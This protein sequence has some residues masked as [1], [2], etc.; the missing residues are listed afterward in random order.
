MLVLHD[1]LMQ[2]HD[3][4]RGHPEQPARLAAVKAALEDHPGLSWRVPQPGAREAIERVH[5][6]RYVEQIARL[7]GKSGALDGDTHLSTASVDAAFLAAGAAIDAVDAVMGGEHDR[8][9]A[10]V[11]PPGHH[12]ESSRAM[13]FCIFNNVAVA[14]AHAIAAHGLQ[15]VLV[16]DWDVH[17]GNGTQHSFS[18]RRDILFVSLHQFPFY[19]GTGAAEESGEGE[20]AGFTIN[21]PF[22]AGCDDQDYRAAFADLILPAADAFAP[23]LVLISAGFDAHRRDPLASMQVTEEGYAD[24]AAALKAVAD[25][26]AKGRMVLTLEGGYDLAALGQSAR[27]AVDVL[28]GATAAEG[29]ASPKRG[30]SAITQVRSHHK[31]LGGPLAGKSC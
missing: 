10:L 11:R 1:D 31:A 6:P 27:A 26:H 17:H 25:R 30:A 3:P 15:R 14:A 19:P 18:R 2:E 7:R 16:V 20:G 4:G 23:E 12:A 9:F 8:A 21:V 5:A 28:E 24:M 22:P 29:P 13:G